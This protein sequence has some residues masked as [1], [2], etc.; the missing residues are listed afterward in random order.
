MGSG[1]DIY[2]DQVKDN[3]SKN[4]YM[5][6]Y[7]EMYDKSIGSMMQAASSYEQNLRTGTNEYNTWLKQAQ[8]EMIAG[9]NKAMQITEP[10]RVNAK[11]AYDEYSRL[12]GLTPASSASTIRGVLE[13]FTSAKKI[14]DSGVDL[15]AISSL[16]PKFAGIDNLSTDERK[17]FKA[18]LT[19]ALSSLP[20]QLKGSLDT[21]QEKA[22]RLASLTEKIDNLYSGVNAGWYA[23]QQKSGDWSP[24]RRVIGE[25][26]ALA[27]QNPE[28]AGAISRG[29]AQ[30]EQNGTLDHLGGGNT[31]NNKNPWYSGKTGMYWNA[32]PYEGVPWWGNEIQSTIQ[33]ANADLASIKEKYNNV[34]TLSKDITDN[35]AKNFEEEWAPGYTPAQVNDKI[36]SNPGFNSQMRQGTSAVQRSAAAKGMLGSGNTLLAVQD[37]AQGLTNQTYQG[38]LN[39]LQQAYGMAA[40]YTDASIQNIMGIAGTQSGTSS[41]LGVNQLNMYTGI[42][43]AYQQAYMAQAGLQGQMAQ[44]FENQGYESLQSLLKQNAQASSQAMSAG[45]QLAGN[46]MQYNLGN[47][48]LA[49]QMYNSQQGYLGAMSPYFSGTNSMGGGYSFGQGGWLVQ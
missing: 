26:N 33:G 41:Q 21:A 11:A 5:Q 42:G 1:I 25:L 28:V 29:I 12:L 14:K 9:Y 4:P 40:P 35:V 19:S 8:E 20:G 7:Q 15:S 49:N 43:Q 45:A 48:Q 30:M 22:T 6:K 24:Q 44:T 13:D 27:Q 2:Y 32:D 3:F 18:N 36:E 10:Y 37:Y 16:M 38:M 17:Q 31:G 46:A 34:S 47:K 39:N 23:E